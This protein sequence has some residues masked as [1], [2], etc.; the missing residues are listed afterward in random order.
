MRIVATTIHFSEKTATKG[1][2]FTSPRVFKFSVFVKEYLLFRSF[3]SGGAYVMS[4][5]IK[6]WLVVWRF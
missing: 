3:K 5:V 2:F 4:L 1:N 6:L